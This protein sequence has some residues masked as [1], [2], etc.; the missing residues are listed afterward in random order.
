LESADELVTKAK[1]S[2]AD[3]FF[4][5]G[6]FPDGVVTVKA[7]KSFD[8]NPRFFVQCVGS[9]I[10]DWTKELGEDGNYAFSGTAIH[11]KLPFEGIEA[12]NQVTKEK[13][14]AEQAPQYFLFGYAWLQTLQ[15]GV[16]G[17]G[18]LDQTAIRDYLKSHEV[19]TI[20]GSFNF[21]E[22]G[23]PSPYSYLTQIQPTG[24]EL[25]WP[26]EVQSAEPIYPKPA[27]SE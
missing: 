18:S 22:R 25:V 5:N 20:G 8:Y 14:E 27:W 21:D 17:A 24:V 1:D 15:V 23:L 3:I 10:P 13:Y 12:L 16:E 4:A 2:G 11:S 26:S 6:F 19:A 7:M 9:T